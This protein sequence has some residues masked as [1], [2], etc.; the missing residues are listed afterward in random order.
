LRNSIPQAVAKVLAQSVSVFSGSYQNHIKWPEFA[1]WCKSRPNG[2]PT[3]K[4]FD[5]WLLQQKPQWRN[6]V[7]A[8]SED[9][10]G[11]THNGHF[12]TD[13]EADAQAKAHPEIITELK[14]AVRRPNGTVKTLATRHAPEQ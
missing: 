9:E 11:Y 12:L 10:P 1:T 2:S 5:K 3:A 4:G 13:F 7:K 14:P 8:V 6:K